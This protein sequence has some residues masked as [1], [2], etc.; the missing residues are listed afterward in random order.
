MIHGSLRFADR[1][2]TP[3]E[4]LGKLAFVVCADLAIMASA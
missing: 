3:R 4:V 2:E 1:C